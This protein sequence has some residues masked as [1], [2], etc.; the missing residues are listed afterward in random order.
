MECRSRVE[1]KV[2]TQS[3]RGAY[4]SPP[5]YRGS[6]LQSDFLPLQLSYP[7]V[8]KASASSV[9]CSISC[10]FA[11]PVAAARRKSL[12]CWKA[13]PAPKQYRAPRCGARIPPPVP[14]LET[15]TSAPGK[16][17]P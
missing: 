3:F 1:S 12:P 10:A 15:D 14:P 9:F 6:L 17:S 4:E 16:Q 11:D 2:T 5:P 7:C 13:L 8:V